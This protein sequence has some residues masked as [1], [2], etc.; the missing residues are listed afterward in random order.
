M[1]CQSSAASCRRSLVCGSGAVCKRNAMYWLVALIGDP[2]VGACNLHVQAN[3]SMRTLGIR[4]VGPKDAKLRMACRSRF[5]LP[6]SSCSDVVGG[7]SCAA[8]ASAS[9]FR[10]GPHQ[11]GRDGGCQGAVDQPLSE[12][13]ALADLRD[14]ALLGGNASAFQASH[15]MARDSRLF[16]GA[17]VKVVVNK[18]GGRSTR[19]MFTSWKRVPHSVALASSSA[20]GVGV[21]R[22]AATRPTA[23]G[24]D[25]LR[26]APRP[27][28]QDRV[29]GRPP[30]APAA[31]FFKSRRE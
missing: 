14:L 11:N 22:G 21:G 29:A 9:P 10:A 17:H 31:R 25:R 28:G 8:R 19:F 26:A 24:H 7:P 30:I 3:L 6:S 12:Q 18:E 4:A 23:D 1:G 16:V 27:A 5:C 2:A 20:W 15:V 13:G